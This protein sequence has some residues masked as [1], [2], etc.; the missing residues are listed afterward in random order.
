MDKTRHK[1]QVRAIPG[2]DSRAHPRSTLPAIAAAAYKLRDEL[3]VG[4]DDG[5]AEH[6]IVVTPE[7]V[8]G[9]VKRCW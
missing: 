8:S 5:W 6:E 1:C 4:I 7:D 2:S 9:A 3:L